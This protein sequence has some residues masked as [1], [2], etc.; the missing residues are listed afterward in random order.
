[1]SGPPDL[2]GIP[3]SGGPGASAQWS[4]ISVRDVIG[5]SR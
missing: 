1:M 3:E 2:S 5:A 4:E